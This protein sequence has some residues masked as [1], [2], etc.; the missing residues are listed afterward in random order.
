MLA[1]RGEDL[2][3]IVRI[4]EQA[5]KDSIGNRFRRILNQ[6]LGIDRFLKAQTVAL[7]TGAIGRV[8]RKIARLQIVNGMSVLRARQRQRVFQQFALGPLGG[9]AIGQ[10]VHIHI[11]VSQGSRLLD[12]LGN[13][14]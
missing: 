14:A 6:R 12:G 3:V 9:I 2:G 11:A 8:E 4:A 13:T 5:A 10:H 1:D 7:G